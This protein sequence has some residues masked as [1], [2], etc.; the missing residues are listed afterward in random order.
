MA[1][2]P[3]SISCRSTVGFDT[4]L[5]RGELLITGQSYDGRAAR[6]A[7]RRSPEAGLTA[8]AYL[9]A[10]GMAAGEVDCAELHGRVVRLTHPDMSPQELADVARDL[11]RGAFHRIGDATSPPTAPVGKGIGGPQPADVA[12]LAAQPQPGPGAPPRWRS[13]TPASRRAASG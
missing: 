11:G 8:R 6:P 2:S 13:S 9:D 3:S 10:L 5:A 4:L 7:R 12:R 1:P